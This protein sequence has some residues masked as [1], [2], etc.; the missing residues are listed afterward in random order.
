MSTSS[1]LD[2][3]KVG[4]WV[5]TADDEIVGQGETIEDAI[6]D[7]EGSGISVDEIVLQR[8]SPPGTYIL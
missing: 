2:G 1:L 8:V 6:L 5:A 4:D 3:L 7:A